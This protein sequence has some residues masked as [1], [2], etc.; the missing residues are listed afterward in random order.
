[1]DDLKPQALELLMFLVDQGAADRDEIAETFWADH[2][3][4]RQTANLHMAIYSIRRKLGKHSVVLDGTVYRLNAELPLM[5]DVELFEQASRVVSSLPPGDPRRLFA[6]TEATSLYKGK[7]LPEYFSD[8]V[9]ERRRLLELEFLD[10]AADHAEEA[11]LRDQPDRALDSLRTALSLD[12]Y[13]DD[14]NEK[15]LRVLSRL[16][17]RSDVMAHYRR[18]ANLMREDLGLE[19]SKSLIELHEEIAGRS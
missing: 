16:D 1:M 12:P 18:Y 19:P 15:Y 3:A 6:L 14:I 8:W 7:Y 11:L 17:R 10:I 2:P 4:G 13:R 9:Q 5:Y